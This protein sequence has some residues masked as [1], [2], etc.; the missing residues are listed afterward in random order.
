LRLAFQAH[1]GLTSIVHQKQRGICW[2]WAACVSMVRQGLGCALRQCA[3]ASMVLPKICPDCAEPC[4]A[5]EEVYDDCDAP[6]PIECIEALWKEF[7]VQ[8]APPQGPVGNQAVLDELE[9]GRALQILLGSSAD[10]G[11]LVLM[12]DAKRDSDESI[13]ILVADPSSDV[14]EVSPKNLTEALEN[15]NWG[16]WQLTWTGLHL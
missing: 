12:I 4:N 15:L 5:E 2:C 8:A 11:H 6:Y 14:H 3:L 10:G 9:K 16:E 7:K 13:K 1:V